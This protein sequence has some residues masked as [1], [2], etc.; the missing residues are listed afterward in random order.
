MPTLCTFPIVILLHKNIISYEQSKVKFMPLNY[1][2]LHIRNVVFFQSMDYNKIIP[3][4][5]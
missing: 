3:Q 5:K 1:K 2:N 4:E